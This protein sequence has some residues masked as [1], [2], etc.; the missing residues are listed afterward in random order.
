MGGEPGTPHVPVGPHGVAGVETHRTGHGPDVGIMCQAPAAVDAV[1]GLGG[2]F[3]R[4]LQFLHEGE[5]RL[6]HLGQRSRL[7]RP[8]VFL[9]ID[10][11][12]VVARPGRQ[13]ALV[14]QALQVGRHIG[15]ARATDKQVAAI[16]EIEGFEVGI[17]E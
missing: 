8:V 12:G 4:A 5:E 2:E 10:I 9:H 17:E 6:V 11:A 15:R 13:D 7:G 3:A 1:V 16:L 14:P